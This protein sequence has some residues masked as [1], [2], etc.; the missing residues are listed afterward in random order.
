MIELEQE[1]PICYKCK[2]S[3]QAKGG[4]TTNLFDYKCDN[5]DYIL[6]DYHF[7]NSHNRPTLLWTDELNRPIMNETNMCGDQYVKS[8]EDYLKSHPNSSVH[9]FT[10]VQFTIKELHNFLAIVITMAIISSLKYLVI[11]EQV[12]HF[13]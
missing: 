9:Y 4:N 8:H 1:R 7:I 2:K 5:R 12:S 11:G 3:V 10:H 6:Y 13:H